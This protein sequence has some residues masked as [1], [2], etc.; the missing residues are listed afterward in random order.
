MELRRRLGISGSGSGLGI[1]DSCVAYEAGQLR[2]LRAVAGHAVRIFNIFQG[3]RNIEGVRCTSFSVFD[4]IA[5]RAA[6]SGTSL[7]V[8]H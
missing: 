2:S 4:G 8:E 7:D 3:E 6:R 1:G 5:G